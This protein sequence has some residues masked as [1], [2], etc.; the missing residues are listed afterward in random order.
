I[1]STGYLL[2][3]TISNK[4]LIILLSKIEYIGIAIVPV[5]WFSFSA[6]YTDRFPR[7]TKTKLFYLLMIIPVI[8]SILVFTNE[9]HNLVW[10]QIGFSNI[11]GYSVLRPKYGIWFWVH[12][13]YS[14]VLFTVGSVMIIVNAILS[15]SIYRKRSIM[16]AIATLTPWVGNISYVF[17]VITIDISPP[18]FVISMVFM[19]IALYRYRLIEILPMAREEIIEMMDDALVVLDE[20][21]NIIDINPSMESF[22]NLSKREVIGSNIEKIF[23]DYPEIIDLFQSNKD[24]EKRIFTREING[25]RKHYSAKLMLITD[26]SNNILGKLIS[27]HDITDVKEAEE[28]AKEQEK[29][30]RVL[31][32]TLEE[33]VKERTK[34][35]EKLLEEKDLFIHQLCHDLK[36]PLTPLITLLPII[37]ERVDDP[38]TKE[39]LDTTIQSANY[40][41]DLV[42]KTLRLAKLNMP[43]MTINR[44]KID[45]SEEVNKIL[46]RNKTILEEHNIEVKNLL[47]KDITV[48]ADKVYL[49]ELFENLLDNAV[50]FTPDGGKI[51]IKA[52]KRRDNEI[53][54]AIQD[55][56]IGMT[57]EQIKKDF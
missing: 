33:K 29:K 25:Q 12:T 54:I 45:L 56:G 36:T 31:N 55:T 51:I 42:L 57:E 1:W 8:T 13:I 19:L 52:E 32:K 18:Y 10:S 49:D 23:K 9:Y 26:P 35:I 28:Y 7:L 53:K 15:P 37:R 16:L 20:D 50:K 11:A 27:V 46:E 48:E 47:D 4:N 34:D 21:N 17:G 44:E 40:M 41:K 5:A 39:L 30:L 22:L 43:S 6:A 38:T 2:E 3:I 14:Y 24:F